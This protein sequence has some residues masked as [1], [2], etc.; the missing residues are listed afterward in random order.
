M[1]DV[2]VINNQGQPPSVYQLPNDNNPKL[3]SNS[4]NFVDQI[5]RFA[6]VTVDVGRRKITRGGEAVKVT[7]AEYNLLVV[8]LQNEDRPLDRDA[9]LNAAWGYD[10]YPKTRTVDVHVARL[11]RKLEPDPATPRHFLT[12]HGVGYR[13]L[14]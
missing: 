14:L 10:F 4:S 8:F 12:I 1:H 9:I 2:V 6:D 7:R 13:F 3:P 11:R 5:V